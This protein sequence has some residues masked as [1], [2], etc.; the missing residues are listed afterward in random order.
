MADPEHDALVSERYRA[1]GREEPPQ[2][3]DE[4][5][6]AA[7]RRRRSRWVVPVSIAAVLVL[8]VGVT[9]RVQL[10]APEVA[11]RVAVEPKVMRSPAAAAPAAPE[12]RARAEPP[13]AAQKSAAPAA[14]ARLDESRRAPP[15]AQAA[16]RA[17][18]AGSAGASVAAGKLAATTETPEQWLERI[19]KLRADGQAR[20]ADESF[21]AFKR[22]FPD[23]R[24]PEAMRRRVAPR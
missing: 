13:R 6:V 10:E 21:A 15:A 23:Y 1:L 14:E 16:D 3:L 12:S 17:E 18:V 4:A 2:A 24:I 20:A 9:L 5:I 22:R 19:A 11:E 8:A 7:A